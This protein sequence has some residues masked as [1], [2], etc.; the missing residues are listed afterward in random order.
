MC[1]TNPVSARKKPVHLLSMAL[2]LGVAL[3]AAPGSAAPPPAASSVTIYNCL[4]APTTPVPCGGSGQTCPGHLNVTFSSFNSNDITQTIPYGTSPYIASRPS[5]T[6]SPSSTTLSCA[7]SNGCVIT[8]ATEACGSAGTSVNSCGLDATS[9]TVSQAI[10]LDRIGFDL[11][12]STWTGVCATQI[13]SGCVP[14]P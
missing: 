4:I 11:S 10:E 14:S 9:L 8:G 6:A 1:H 2:A 3:F 12:F 13:C 7:T 5:S